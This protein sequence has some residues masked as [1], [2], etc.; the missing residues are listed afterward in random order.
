MPL[1]FKGIRCDTRKRRNY[2]STVW[3]EYSTYYCTY[4]RV[5]VQYIVCIASQPRDGLAVAAGS[6]AQYSP[7]SFRNGHGMC[8]L[9]YRWSGLDLGRQGCF[10]T[11]HVHVKGSAERTSCFGRVD[12]AEYS[13]VKQCT[14]CSPPVY[15]SSNQCWE[16]DADCRARDGKQVRWVDG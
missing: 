3:Y 12:T 16:G 8:V 2:S 7:G 15:C 14:V 9:Q 10:A 6:S 5:S 11:S 13:R 4:S 1:L